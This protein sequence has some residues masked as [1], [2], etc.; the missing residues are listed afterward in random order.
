MLQRMI[1]AARAL[2]RE[3]VVLQLALRDAR[4]SVL[5]KLLALL[6]CPH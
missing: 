6:E 5:P 2:K 4:V 3:I 1:G